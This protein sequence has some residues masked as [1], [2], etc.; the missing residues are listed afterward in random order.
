MVCHQE[1]FCE[2][3]HRNTEPL[4]HSAGWVSGTTRHCMQCHFPLGAAGCSVCHKEA[5]HSAAIGS[6]HPPFG[7]V[8][9]GCNFCHPIVPQP[10]HP[11]PGFECAICHER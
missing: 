3:C 8:N 4:S 6:P 2:R 1:D 11:N 9:P 7:P 10:P 5:E